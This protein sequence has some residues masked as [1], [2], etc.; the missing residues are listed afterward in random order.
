MDI[1][2]RKAM[3]KWLEHFTS[4]YDIE[5]V[6]KATYDNISANSEISP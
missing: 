2:S 4:E 3:C 6:T 1:R 5:M